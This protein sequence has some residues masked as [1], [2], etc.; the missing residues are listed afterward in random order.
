MF[1]RKLA[2]AAVAGL[3]FSFST[4]A[5]AE[6]FPNK[7]IKI[8]APSSPGGVLDLTS[9]LVADKLSKNLDGHA[10]V[11]ENMPGGGG[12]IG[13]RGMLRAEPDGHTLV[14]GSLG[15]NAA[16]YALYDDLPYEASDFAPVM[17][18]IAMPSVLIVSPDLP[19]TNL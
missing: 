4:V 3:F 15:P 12:I 1:L 18:V 19:V 7:P 13:I 17:N 11:V 9:R 14:M 5:A 2:V 16:N 8:I 10:V 6:E